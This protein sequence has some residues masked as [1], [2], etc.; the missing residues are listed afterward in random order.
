MTPTP[1]IDHY[2]R[3]LHEQRGLVFEDYA[4]LWG[5]SVT[6]LDAFWRS[7]WDHF[8]L[9]SATPFEAALNEERM[10]GAVWFRG[11]TLNIASQALRHTDAAEAAGHPAIVHADEAM[12]ARG[13]LGELRWPELRRQ[14]GALAASLHELGVRRGDRVVAYLPNVPETAVAFLAVASL[15][16]VWSVCSPDMGPVA[17][18]DRFRQIEPK[19]LIAADGV[20]YAGQD[21]DR[22]AML[23]QLLAELPTVGDVVLLGQLDPHADPASLARPADAGK[24]ARRAHRWTDLVAHAG[25][26]EP[27]PVPFDHPLWIVYSSGTTGLPKPIVHGHGGVLLEMLKGSIHNNVGPTVDTGDRFHWYSS[28]GWIM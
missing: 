13:E 5:W 2:R 10:P 18:L 25:T 22:R 6:E 7:I 3:F 15:G 24:D 27:D 1:Q 17:V 21:I 16:A 26:R 23:T 12:L 20:R 28:T 14:V 9:R 8:D 11:A 4:S 19:V